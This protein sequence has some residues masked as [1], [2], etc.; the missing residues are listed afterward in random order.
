[1][2]DP[3][4]VPEDEQDIGYEV[5]RIRKRRGLS[6]QVVADLAGMDKVNL[7]KIERGRRRIT[8]RK[9]LEN[10]A[11]ALGC[12]VTDLTREPYE[13]PDRGTAEA[14]AVLPNL[15]IALYETPGAYDGQARS[16]DEL[17]R[18]V[19]RANVLCEEAKYA[20]ACRDLPEL[21]PELH[22]HELAGGS[23]ER[24]AALAALVEGYVVAFGATRR[25]GRP[26]LAMQ[27]AQRARAA[28]E[29]LADPAY[30][31]FAE[32]T[33]ASGFSRLGVRDAARRV[34]DT[35]MSA[36]EPYANPDA[37]N[38]REAEALG[39]MHLVSAQLTARSGKVDLARDHLDE[40]EA[41]AAHTGERNTLQWRFGRGNVTNWRLSIAVETD[42]G[43]AVAE[44]LEGG[45]PRLVTA[46]R[47]SRFHFDMARAYAQAG[48]GRDLD[49]IRHLDI[50]DRI[51]P[52]RTRLDPLA[53][54]LVRALRRRARRTVW[55]LDSLARRFG[56]A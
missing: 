26:E 22:L 52:A 41:I 25:L 32:L 24:R 46:G 51:A 23:D 3:T 18:A 19:T 7:S 14:L 21:L 39:V 15:T 53:R 37:P 55:E 29:T 17:V 56:V 47:R 43:P 36:I 8:Q 45:P 1:M 30:L 4:E 49:A 34:V 35:A 28:A 40:A 13:A 54:E 44:A 20:Q 6:L 12:A 48:G 9:T 38:P 2:S 10:L 16:V 42:R 31:G 50:A 33:S 5:R 27:A 11:S